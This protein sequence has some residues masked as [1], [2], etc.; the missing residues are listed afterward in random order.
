[1]GKLVGTCFVIVGR[2]IGG[3][4]LQVHDDVRRLNELLRLAGYL[5]TP[6]NPSTDK[7]WA[8]QTTEGLKRL[9]ETLRAQA[10]GDLW[11]GHSRYGGDHIDP[12]AHGNLLHELTARAG[13]LLPIPHRKRGRQ[14][15][16]AFFEGC[17]AKGVP[18]GHTTQTNRMVW[19]LSHRTDYALVTDNQRFFSAT[20]R[21]SLNC[22]S[23]ANIMLA[24]WIHGCVN[25]QPYDAS[26]MVGNYDPL[27]DRFNLH[28]V[29]HG[30]IHEGFVWFANKRADIRQAHAAITAAVR[31]E[32]L[33]YIAS[34][35][36]ASAKIT[37]DMVLL[38]GEVYECNMGGIGPAV[39]KTPLLN[40]LETMARGRKIA[41]LA[42]PSVA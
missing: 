3:G 14:A 11:P 9:S 35:E 25:R 28:G 19:G 2:R 30:Q 27:S 8:K 24:I 17:R 13:V 23:F 26:Q 15:V 4:G 37:H 6:A 33:Y 42:G 10:G 41:Y 20:P 18:Y 40:R 16:L 5:S 12:A 39:R 7:K 31:P 36:E 34:C 22:T 38:G 1:M 21:I 29:H 32:R